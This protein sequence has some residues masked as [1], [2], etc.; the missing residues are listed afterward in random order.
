MVEN[1]TVPKVRIT[2]ITNHTASNSGEY[3]LYWMTAMRRLRYNFGLQ[4]AVQWANELQRPLLILDAVRTNYRWACD[5]F[6]QFLID[7]VVER[8]SQLVSS[9]AAH[10]A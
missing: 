9:R 7:G 4:R 2:A 3:V 10:C 6:H 1:E 8:S 5:R